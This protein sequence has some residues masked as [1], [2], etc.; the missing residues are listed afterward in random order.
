MHKAKCDY[1]RPII[2]GAFT[3]YLSWTMDTS[4][5]LTDTILGCRMCFCVIFGA[6]TYLTDNITPNFPQCKKFHFNNSIISFLRLQ[7]QGEHNN[8]FILIV[9]LP[10]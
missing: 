6:Y 3:T 1:I 8:N 7:S 9:I 4:P 10:E 5:L 2:I